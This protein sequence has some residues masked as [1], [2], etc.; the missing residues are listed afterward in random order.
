MSYKMNIFI[1]III[2]LAFFC[3]IAQPTEISFHPFRIAFKHFGY[4]I[5][6]IFI[7]LGILF[8]HSEAKLSAQREFTAAV[9]ESLQKGLNI[10]AEELDAV[11]N[12]EKT[13]EEIKNS[14]NGIQ[15]NRNE[16]HHED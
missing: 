1:G 4:G 7:V 15:S 14:E 6:T 13:L 8:I 9:K 12:G 16:H 3:I 11:W 10:S 5:G 2:L